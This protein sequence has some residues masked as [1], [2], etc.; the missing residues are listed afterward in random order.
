MS[1]EVNS[2]AYNRSVI[3]RIGFEAE[4]SA[5]SVEIYATV[6]ADGVS[7]EGTFTFTPCVRAGESPEKA[8]QRALR[9]LA[10]GS[11]R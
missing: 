7:L 5:Q 1:I 9:T 11:S 6:T 10:K 4:E 2:I 8:V 3:R